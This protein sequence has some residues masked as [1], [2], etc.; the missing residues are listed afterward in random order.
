MLVNCVKYTSISKYSRNLAGNN[1]KRHNKIVYTK[2][3]TSLLWH[4]IPLKI[5][6]PI[7]NIDLSRVFYLQP[8]SI[9]LVQIGFMIQR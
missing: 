2:H 3:G 8:R 4:Q 6:Y 1:N 5:L 9:L 7:F